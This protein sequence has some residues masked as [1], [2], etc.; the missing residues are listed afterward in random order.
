MI[1]NIPPFKGDT[2][3][4]MMEAIMKDEI[5]FRNPAHFKYSALAVD[6]LKKILNR[7][8]KIRLS[9]SEALRH[10]WLKATPSEK[11]IS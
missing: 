10:K 9:A 7:N 5:L 3:A 4:K 1:Y 8:P 6:F 2:P 11:E